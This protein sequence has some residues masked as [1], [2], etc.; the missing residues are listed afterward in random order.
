M[1]D[2]YHE[3]L[4]SLSYKLV[5]MTR[6]VRSAMARA[7]T[8]L[9]D[10]DLRLAEEVI[11][12]DDQINKITHENAMR[13]YQFD[14]YAVRPREHCTVGALRAEATDVDTVTH[15]GRAPDATDVEYFNRLRTPPSKAAAQR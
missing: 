6:L 9:L 10:A 15:V 4:D 3:E 13:H 5:E 7:T 12:A 2:A 11:S 14:P 8:A 1:R